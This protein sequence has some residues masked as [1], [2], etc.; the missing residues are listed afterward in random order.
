MLNG[1][2]NRRGRPMFMTSGKEN[3]NTQCSVKTSVFHMCKTPKHWYHNNATNRTTNS[4]QNTDGGD[5]NIKR[6]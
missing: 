4:V 5:E 3:G 6:K 2:P 1:A